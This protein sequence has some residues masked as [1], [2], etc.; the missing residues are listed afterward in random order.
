M[1]GL[2]DYILGMFGLA[3]IAVSMAIAGRTARRAALPGWT[4]AP[5]LL[6]DGILAIALLIAVS[7]LLGLL[8][9]LD[10]PVLVLSCLIVGG[11]GVRLEPLLIRAAKRGS[12]TGRWPESR[13]REAPPV[14]RLE[15][16]AA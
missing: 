15:I 13:E 5:A 16:G 6:A 1:D 10:G 7:E 9:L 4:G 8:G 3:L 12:K 14:S 2:G 11:G